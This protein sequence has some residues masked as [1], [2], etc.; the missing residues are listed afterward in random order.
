M[1]PDIS[2]AIPPLEDLLAWNEALQKISMQSSHNLFRLGGAGMNP[3]DSICL[4]IDEFQHRSEGGRIDLAGLMAVEKFEKALQHIHKG[5]AAQWWSWFRIC[6]V[7]S[8]MLHEYAYDEEARNRIWRA[9]HVWSRQC[10]HY[11]EGENVDMVLK[12]SDKK[13]SGLLLLL[14]LVEHDNPGSQ[15]RLDQW[16][17]PSK[18]F[19]LRHADSQ[20]DSFR[21]HA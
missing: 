10:A 5:R 15:V 1:D 20:Q 17:M 3:Q 8:T 6:G 19:P 21:Q 11:D 16:Q 7:T 12:A 2:L 18:Q 4:Y 13:V 14:R 9:F